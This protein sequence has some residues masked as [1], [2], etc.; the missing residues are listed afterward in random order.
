MAKLAEGVGIHDWAST[1]YG[2]SSGNEAWRNNFN[3]GWAAGDW[4]GNHNAQ[5]FEA[6]KISEGGGQYTHGADGN[7]Y[8][9]GADG[10]M[11]QVARPND[12]G[13]KSEIIGR[14]VEAVATGPKTTP[15]VVPAGGRAP[16]A[17]NKMGAKPTAYL[18]GGQFSPNAAAF[19]ASVAGTGKSKKRKDA[20]AALWS[21][22]S[23][24]FPTL[25]TKQTARV[26]GGVTVLPAPGFS[27]AEAHEQRIGDEGPMMWLYQG[28]N[29]LADWSYTIEQ[30]KQNPSMKQPDWFSNFIMVQDFADKY[31][32]GTMKEIEAIKSGYAATMDALGKAAYSAPIDKHPQYDAAWDAYS[33]ATDAFDFKGGW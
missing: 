3:G 30:A 16:V 19:N 26:V 2:N 4:T 8:A 25:E 22:E 28:V 20:E 23:E 9:L 27:D 31:V 1:D 11:H 7:Y 17:V 21:A 6:K 24:L 18:L 13:D 10:R 33:K 12:A 14:V 15:V 32:G 5:I 29:E